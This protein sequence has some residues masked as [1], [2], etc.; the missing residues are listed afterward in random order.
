MAENKESQ[1]EQWLK[2][3]S[4]EITKNE[5][6]LLASSA[7][8]DSPVPQMDPSNDPVTDAR[9][10][11]PPLLSGKLA[12][13][14]STK[15]PREFKESPERLISKN[16]PITI[17]DNDVRAAV[18]MSVILASH[19]T[20]FAS[21]TIS[22]A[23]LLQ[24]REQI[25]KTFGAHDAVLL[26]IEA[27]DLLKW[28]AGAM[29]EE[30]MASVPVV[31]QKEDQG[32]LDHIAV[33]KRAIDEKLDLD[34]TYYTGTRAEFSTRRITPIEIDAEKYLIAYCH[35]R[36]ENRRFRLSRILSLNWIEPTQH[37]LFEGMEDK[38]PV[39][40]P[41]KEE[42]LESKAALASDDEQEKESSWPQVEDVTKGVFSHTAP[43]PASSQTHELKTKKEKKTSHA[44]TPQKTAWI[45]DS[46]VDNA[47][48]KRSEEHARQVTLPD[49]E[50]EDTQRADHKKRSKKDPPKTTGF[51]PGFE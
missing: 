22:E 34:M 29:N 50:P 6:S 38:E 1:F 46:Q 39:H 28:F 5:P 13:Y 18:A 2:N 11:P 17:T 4:A 3:R 14:L 45:P 40:L 20:R 49:V 33:L 36:K 41:S 42:Y 10:L 15:K 16:V 51:L 32:L 24:F 31:S 44:E 47:R 27:Y 26:E 7:S 25:L 30:W 35:T 23:A 48:K 43:P 9:H 37:A 8:S 19:L 21:T 12:D